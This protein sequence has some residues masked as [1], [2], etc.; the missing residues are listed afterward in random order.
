MEEGCRK[1]REK[2]SD[3]GVLQDTIKVPPKDFVLSLPWGPQQLIGAGLGWA[4]LGS[5]SRVRT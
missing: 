2:A 4:G 5:G 1:G 3:P